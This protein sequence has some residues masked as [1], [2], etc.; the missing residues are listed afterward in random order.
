[1]VIITQKFN[2]FGNHLLLTSHFL[3]NALEHGYELAITSFGP[4]VSFF[5]GT[6][7]PGPSR[8]GPVPV[9]LRPGRLR[10]HSG[11]AQLLFH[12]GLVLRPGAPVPPA[13]RRTARCLTRRL[14]S[15]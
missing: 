4:F 11:A 10:L 7:E 3:A 5:E 2:G 14:H 12:A 6:A 15:I 9:R 1:M 8:F 13:P